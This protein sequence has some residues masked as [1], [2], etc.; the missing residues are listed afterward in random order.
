MGQIRF[1][2]D[3]LGRLVAA[4][5]GLFDL[6]NSNQND[7]AR[8]SIIYFGDDGIGRIK[9]SNHNSNQNNME[10][11]ITKDKVLAAAD[12]CGTAKAVLKTL[13]PEAFQ[14]ESVFEKDAKISSPNGDLV[15]RYS[16][17]SDLKNNHLLLC[18]KRYDFELV[19]ARENLYLKV[20]PK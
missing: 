13:F 15:I 1:W 2:R 10:L 5:P 16:D 12:Q 11:K 7:M 4:G 20:T 9:H 14:S 3:D 19:E 18:D 6:N 8:H 17:W